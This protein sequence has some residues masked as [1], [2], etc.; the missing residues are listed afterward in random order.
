MSA[1]Y[2]EENIMPKDNSKAAR[3]RRQDSATER[4]ARYDG[5]TLRQKVEQARARIGNSKKEI[6]RLES[7]EQD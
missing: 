2:S 4:K 1:I 5:L 6:S 3:T 7:Q